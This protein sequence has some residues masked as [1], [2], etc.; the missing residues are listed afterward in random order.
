MKVV[1]K[2]WILLFGVLILA[3]AANADS[4]H[5]QLK[6]LVAQLQKSPSDS[7]LREKIITLARK[8]KPAPAV[9]EDAR[10]HFVKAVTLQKDA[11]SPEDYDLPIQEYQQALL[12]APWWSDAYY[13]LSSAL[14]LKQQYTEAIQNL[15]L[16]ILA[17][18]AGPDARAAQDKVYAL[19]AKSEKANS[20]ENSPAGKLDKFYKSLDGGRWEKRTGYAHNYKNGSDWGETSVSDS[21]VYLEVRGHE[22][23]S[24]PRDQC[25][26]GCDTTTFDSRE[27]EF[28]GRLAG[29]F[30]KKVRVKISDD[31]QS[32]VVENWAQPQPSMYWKSVYK[33]IK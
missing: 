29:G 11:K 23:I 32:I 31:G 12:L 17:S 26:D 33:R 5:E 16:S 30:Q 19:E 25:N 28:M 18:P 6:Q 27:F 8:L 13:D 22:L 20:Y 4:A 7:A 2:L 14:E 3:N 9:P 15:K 1:V 10:R 24:Y 21:N